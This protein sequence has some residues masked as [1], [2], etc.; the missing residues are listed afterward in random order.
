MKKNKIWIFKSTRQMTVSIILFCLFMLGFIYFGSKDYKVNK[1]TDSEKFVSE[2]KEVVGDNVFTYINASDVYTYIRRPD[3]LI[4]FGIRNS[5]WV[6]YYANVL[7]E[8]AK[9]IGITQI[10]Y[11]DITDDRKDG[12]ATYES[13][14]YY[15]KDYVTYLDDGKMNL[16][17]PTLLIKTD[18]V[19]TYFDDE[20][21]V[22]KGSVSAAD[23]W[24]NYQTNLK[25]ETLKVALQDYMKG[26]S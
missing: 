25:K 22:I 23:Y 17:G 12:N 4:L 9:E 5:D 18:G 6:G 24:D 15:L 10:Y 1:I 11:Y 19:I 2:H 7:N 16:Y 26:V 8:V 13:I 14:V 3:V 20:T 21:A